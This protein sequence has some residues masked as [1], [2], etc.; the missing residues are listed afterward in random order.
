M[1]HQMSSEMQACIDACL[2]CHSVCLSMVTNHCLPAGGAHAA[3]EHI[4]VMLDC[5]QI[6]AASAD[7]MLRGS[8]HHAHVCRV[9]ADICEAC[10]QSCQ[11]LDGME[12]CVAACRACAE[13]CRSMGAMA[14]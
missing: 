1:H 5:A 9:C 12:E 8:A 11:G 14:H 6:C 2:R 10:A 3:P 13:S 7:F 4:K